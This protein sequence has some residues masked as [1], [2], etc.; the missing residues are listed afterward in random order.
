MQKRFLRFM[1][2]NNLNTDHFEQMPL[3]VVNGKELTWKE[4]GKT[5]LTH[6][7]FR[8]VLKF[9]DQQQIQTTV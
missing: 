2:D 7:G 4:F 8:F 6:D 3:I 9:V 5:V 1:R